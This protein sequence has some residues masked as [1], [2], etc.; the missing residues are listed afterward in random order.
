MGVRR[1]GHRKVGIVAVTVRRFIAVV[2]M[3]A[4]AG[5]NSASQLT[6]L[7]VGGIAGGATANPAIGYAVG[8]GTD[9]A[10]NA[11][12]KWFGRSRQGAEQDAIAQAAGD[13]PVGG[14]ADWK[15]EHTIPFG[16]EHGKLHVTR[17]IDSP[18]VACKE[19]AF[20]VDEGSEKEP[21]IHWY[22][23]DICK[24]AE[25]WKWASAE[26]AVERWGYLQ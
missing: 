9:A 13:L 24:S 20:S 4:L 5:C 23:T 3:G 26:P 14:S 12:L 15:I 2:A 16:N 18:L 21:K 25:S 11:G 17:T 19:I 22:L 8:I 7:V 10:T 6:G 1:T